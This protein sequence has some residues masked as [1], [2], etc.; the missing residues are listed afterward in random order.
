[1][2]AGREVMK[3][4][5]VVGLQSFYSKEWPKFCDFTILCSDGSV[6]VLRT[7]L[8]I[9]SE[10]FQALF[11]IYPDTKQSDLSQF[12]TNTIK[13]I[14]KNVYLRWKTRKA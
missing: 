3:R 8:E 12:D 9:S 14:Y 6:P 4:S 13:F 1:M 2:E 10:Y 7:L 11:R 5:L